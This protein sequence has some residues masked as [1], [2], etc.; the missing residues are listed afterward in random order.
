[1]VCLFAHSQAPFVG[2]LIRKVVPQTGALSGVQCN[3]DPIG[4]NYTSVQC[5]NLTKLH[6]FW[7]SFD[8]RAGK[9]LASE[10]P[11]LMSA[12]GLV[13]ITELRPTQITVGMH[14]VAIKRDRIRAKMAAKGQA[15]PVN[16]AV[17]IVVG[18]DSSYFMIDR[19]HF[20]R[21]LYEVGVKDVAV[22]FVADLSRLGRD[23]FW[24]ELDRRGWTHPIDEFG[25]RQAYDG[26]PASVEMLIDD[27]FR[28]LASALRRMGGY[29]KI[30]V[31]FSEFRWADFLRQRIERTV[32]EQGFENAIRL[33]TDLS[34][35]AEAAHLPGWRGP[36]PVH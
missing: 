12:L 20:V 15:T 14:E 29:R 34:A 31:P 24:P 32:V 13:A 28:S 2:R 4:L 19:H 6:M 1:L 18:P 30:E 17:P 36:R 3:T 23:H 27:P 33:A 21:A 7:R 10:R 22:Q 9:P 25:R 26:I 5:R 11:L 35:S 16:R 8:G